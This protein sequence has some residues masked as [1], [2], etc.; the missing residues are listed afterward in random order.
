VGC[1]GIQINVNQHKHLT[2]IIK[3]EIQIW[4]QLNTWNINI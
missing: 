1:W 3:T 2:N 4:R